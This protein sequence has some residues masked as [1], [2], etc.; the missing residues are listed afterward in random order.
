MTRG[1]LFLQ[2]LVAAGDAEDLDALYRALS[3][4]DRGAECQRRAAAARPRT[5]CPTPTTCAAT[6][7]DALDA[8]T[9]EVSGV[10][11][12]E[13]SGDANADD[14]GDRTTRSARCGC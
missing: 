14:G 10:A 12:S 2:K 4:A 8:A 5:R 6:L 13:V 11:V 3:V 1:G 9:A 7:A